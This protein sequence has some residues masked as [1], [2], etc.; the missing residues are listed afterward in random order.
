[1]VYNKS[2]IKYQKSK[3]QEMTRI[4]AKKQM[5]NFLRKSYIYP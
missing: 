3:M 4:I 2:K 5:K 1:M